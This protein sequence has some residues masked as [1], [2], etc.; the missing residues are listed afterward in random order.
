MTSHTYNIATLSYPDRGVRCIDATKREA[1][2]IS[3]LLL[4]HDSSVLQKF[5]SAYRCMTWCRF[6]ASKHTSNVII[7]LVRPVRVSTIANKFGSRQSLIS[8]P[9]SL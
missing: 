1:A 8:R 3:L 2:F 5:T 6:F 7:D 4:V 9:R